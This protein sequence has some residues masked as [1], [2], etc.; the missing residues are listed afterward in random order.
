MADK[1]ITLDVKTDRKKIDDLIKSLQNNQKIPIELTPND[2]KLKTSIGDF[3]KQVEDISGKEIDITT[4]IPEVTD[5]VKGLQTELEKRIEIAIDTQKSAT[6]IREFKKAQKELQ[7]ILLEIGDD[8]S[9]D[10]ERVAVAIGTGNDKVDELNDK[11]K[12]LSK[13]PIENLS[14]GFKGG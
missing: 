1:T 5:E 8:G 11:I 4:N 12:S 10:F 6:S 14:A 7:G 2:K 3:R 13:A 9:K